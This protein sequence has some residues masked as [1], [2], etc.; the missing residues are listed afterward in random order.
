[1]NN[2]S[3]RLKKRRQELGLSQVKL[4]KKVGLTQGAIAQLEI[5]RNQNTIKLIELAASLNTTPEWLLYG[6]GDSSS[7]YISKEIKPSNFIKIQ[8][9][10]FKFDIK[11]LEKITPNKKSLAGYQQSD[12]SMSPTINSSDYIIYDSS[13]RAIV[14]NCIFLI[15]RNTNHLIRRVVFDKTG[16]IVYRCDNLEK[17]K[18]TDTYTLQNDKILGRVI[19]AGGYKQF[20]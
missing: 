17:V 6:T 14:E 11:F 10:P 18:Y 3:T 19:W 16:M 7:D 15:K 9:I 20:K 8:D 4:A 13:D 5:G 2:L 1:M 12:D